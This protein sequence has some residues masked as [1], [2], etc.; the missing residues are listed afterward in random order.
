MVA[1][2]AQFSELSGKGLVTVGYVR[3]IRND[4]NQCIKEKTC[5]IVTSI[6]RFNNGTKTV[7]KIN[8][9]LLT[10]LRPVH[11]L[12]S[13]FSDKVSFCKTL[14]NIYQNLSRCYFNYIRIKSVHFEIKWH[15][16]QFFLIDWVFFC[17]KQILR[18]PTLPKSWFGWAHLKI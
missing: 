10:N 2:V 1:S 14:D 15:Q 5:I 11:L 4:L 16:W 9:I 8:F 12:L 18:S 7:L 13:R 17:Q 6:Q 3:A